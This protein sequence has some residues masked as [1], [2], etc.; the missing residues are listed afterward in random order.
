MN[1]TWFLDAANL[2]RKFSI[3]IKIQFLG[4]KEVNLE[5]KLYYYNKNSIS[6]LKI[7]EETRMRRNTKPHGSQWKLLARNQ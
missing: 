1:G 3:I 5:R 6:W 7:N 4:Q 2:A